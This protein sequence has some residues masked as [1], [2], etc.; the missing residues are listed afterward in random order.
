[1][2]EQLSHEKSVLAAQNA[3][4]VKS[5]NEKESQFQ[6]EI[7]EL[8]LKLESQENTH[9]KELIQLEQRYQSIQ[10]ELH[11]KETIPTITTTSITIASPEVAQI[12]PTIPDSSS[13]SSYRELCEI[14]E[15]NV[16][17]I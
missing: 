14:N 12:T 9:Q 3:S 5:H 16:K 4:L 1:M 13:A 10:K 6:R 17:K 7:C 11:E 15:A 2:A 8:R